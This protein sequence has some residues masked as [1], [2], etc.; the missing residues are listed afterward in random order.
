MNLINFYMFYIYSS[1]L[2]IFSSFPSLA[3]RFLGS[4]SFKFYIF[5][6]L[7]NF[8][9]FLFLI[10]F[11]CSQKVY[12]DFF[13]KLTNILSGKCFKSIRKEYPSAVVGEE[14]Y[15]SLLVQL[16]IVLF[17]FSVSFLIFLSDFS[18]HYQM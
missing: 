14:F 6:V 7:S 4:M 5:V 16:V 1:H 12:I 10:S 3:Y 17:R 15:K 11:Y 13:N 9:L 2:K 18:I 8:L